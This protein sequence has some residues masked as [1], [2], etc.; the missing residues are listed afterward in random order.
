MQTESKW[1]RLAR[2]IRSI[3][4]FKCERLLCFFFLPHKQNDC[5]HFTFLWGSRFFSP[6]LVG[7]LTMVASCAFWVCVCVCVFSLKRQVFRTCIINSGGYQSFLL[8]IRQMSRGRI[9]KHKRLKRWNHLLCYLLANFNDTMCFW[10]DST[11]IFFFRTW[12]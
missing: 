5:A 1:L 3:C 10:I 9:A 6:I 12:L 8:Q 7:T 2:A 11:M 4:C